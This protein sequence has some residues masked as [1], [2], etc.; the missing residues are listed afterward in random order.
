MTMAS[1]QDTRPPRDQDLSTCSKVDLGTRLK[2]S[3]LS[4]AVFTIIIVL[5]QEF[6][7][8]S[9]VMTASVPRYKLSKNTTV[10]SGR[11]PPLTSSVSTATFSDEALKQMRNATVGLHPRNHLKIRFMLGNSSSKCGGGRKKSCRS[12]S[13]LVQ[14]IGQYRTCAVVA[15]GGILL[16]S[17]CGADIDAKDYVI[18]TNLPALVGFERDVGQKTNMT[19]VNTN[20]VKRMAECS[21]LKDRTRDPYPTR[22]R[23]I[24]NTVLVGNKVS[25]RALR[26]AAQRNKVS[27]AFWTCRTCDLRRNTRINSIAS[28]IAGWKFHSRPS[29]GLATVLIMSTFCDHLYLYG[30]FPFSTDKNN[31]EIPYHYFPDDA[32]AEPIFQREKHHMDV[33]YRLYKELHRRGVLQVQDGKCE[34]QEKGN[35]SSPDP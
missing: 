17:D 2:V 28:K 19:F 23:S 14:P 10:Q 29:S 4:L 31:K 35:T 15:N 20:V 30:F 18:R 7:V 34:R 21:L 8:L 27:L 12:K 13:G 25:Q 5:Q 3:V 22:L 26:A 16:G 32:V 11:T 1:K 33:E 6:Y 9:G 24:N